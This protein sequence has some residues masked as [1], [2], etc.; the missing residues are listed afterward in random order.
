MVCR[1][2]GSWSSLSRIAR[3]K[4]VSNP[5]TDPAN[6]FN[7]AYARGQFWAQEARIGG[8]ACNAPHCSETEV[9]CRRSVQLLFQMDSVTEY[10]SAIEG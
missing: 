1:P 8:L 7:A 9:D 2:H 10:D 6:A 4:P 3:A 5:D